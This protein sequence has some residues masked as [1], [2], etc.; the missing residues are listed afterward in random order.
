M[1]NSYICRYK[2]ILT[3]IKDFV[4][5]IRRAVMV[6]FSVN[7]TGLRDTDIAGRASL[8]CVLVR[9]FL[10]ELCHWSEDCIREFHL[11]RK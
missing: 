3:F 8:L 5:W 11:Q 1:V 4:G 10:E 9:V 7:L 2:N 6:N